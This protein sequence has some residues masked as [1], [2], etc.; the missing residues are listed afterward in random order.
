MTERPSRNTCMSS[1]GARAIIDKPLLRLHRK[2]SLQNLPHIDLSLRSVH[3]VIVKSHPPADG[4]IRALRRTIIR[5][6]ISTGNCGWRQLLQLITA[7]SRHSLTDL[8]KLLSLDRTQLRATVPEHPLHPAGEPRHNGTLQV[9][10]E[11]TDL[12]VAFDLDANGTRFVAFLTQSKR[13]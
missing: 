6:A 7:G 3:T 2:L 9:A 11:L 12:R 13:A 1:G 4:L 8:H 10:L 5:L